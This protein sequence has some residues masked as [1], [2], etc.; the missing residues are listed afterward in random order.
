MASFIFDFSSSA[1]WQAHLEREG[2]VV[3]T[4]IL[5]PE[6]IQ[7]GIQL[8][9]KHM[10]SQYPLLSFDDERSLSAHWPEDDWGFITNDGIAASDFMWWCRTRGKV[11]EVYRQLYNLKN[12]EELVTCFDRANAVRNTRKDTG[13][14]SW[15]HIDY[16]VFDEPPFSCFQGFLNFVDG[17]SDADSPCLRVY[18]GS[19]KDVSV[20]DWV[21]ENYHGCDEAFFEIHDKKAR[22]K[23]NVLAPAGSLVL[24]NSKTMHDGRTSVKAKKRGFGPLR[25]LVAYLCYAPK[26]F[27]RDEKEWA[28]RKQ[29]FEDGSAST[30]WPAWHIR[31]AN[32]GEDER[33]K[34]RAREIERDFP[35]SE[36]LVGVKKNKK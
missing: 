36:W 15:A 4:G 31:E 27:V 32:M 2:F 16:P 19:H 29:I 1:D 10:E 21:R 18:P 25:R 22:Q 6:E 33:C 20:L 24:W 34:K 35:E 30:H 14:D 8:F 5:T 7:N 23:I 13:E 28:L 3:V 12:R 11:L 9:Q 17:T 26:R